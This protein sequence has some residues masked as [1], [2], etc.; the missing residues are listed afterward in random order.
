MNTER[1]LEQL[2]EWMGDVT[3]RVHRA[4][5][6][7][8]EV[9]P[10]FSANTPGNGDVGGGSGSGTSITERLALNDDLAKD[11]ALQD[12]NRLKDVTRQ[13]TPLVREARDIV[14]RWGYT[15]AGEYEPSPRLRSARP[16]EGDTNRAK[17]CTSCARLSKA[18][19]VGDRGRRG[20][21]DWCAS[22]ED[23]E[24]ILPPLALLDM[25]HRGSRITPAL[26]ERLRREERIAPKPKK[27]RPK[28]RR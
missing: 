9:T 26:V 23:K 8:N 6:N 15:T 20:M 22:F 16:T 4:V 13:M 3:S 2:H 25:R 18:E 14:Q 10:G 21:C 1:T 7:L 28:R 11:H 27:N 19:P 17:W 12:L 24:R 5:I